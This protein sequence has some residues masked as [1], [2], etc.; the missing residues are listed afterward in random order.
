MSTARADLAVEVHGLRKQYGDKQAVDGL[1]LSVHRGEIFAVLGPNGAGKTTIVEILEGFRSRDGGSV[2]V[3]GVDPADAD[4]AWRSRIGIVLQTANDQ[5]DL[6]VG[7]LVHH[8][9]R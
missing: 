4:R 6:T 1:D 3:L 7:E 5:A 2:R 8:F 9:A